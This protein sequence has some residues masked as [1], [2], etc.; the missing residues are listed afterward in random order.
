MAY[1]N[2]QKKLCIADALKKVVP[3]DWKYSLAVRHHST[4]VMTI[5]AAPVNFM[6]LE[7]EHLRAELRCGR[8]DGEPNDIAARIGALERGEV[9]CL[10]LDG[11]RM[12]KRF[13][14]TEVAAIFA[15]IVAALNIDNYDNSDPMTD[16][17][18]VGHYVTL[19]VGE[20]DKPFRYIPPEIAAA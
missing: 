12:D 18:D 17:F 19:Q 14:G 11:Y 9:E 15:N 8:L 4:I 1:M 13:T 2:Q 5:R 3:K 7:A 16:Y 6:Q 20:Y 10:T